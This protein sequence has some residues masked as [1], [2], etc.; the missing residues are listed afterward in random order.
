M[1]PFANAGTGCAT[2]A[3]DTFHRRRCDRRR[4][5]AKHTDAGRGRPP[6]I[7]RGRHAKQKNRSP[8]PPPSQVLAR[9]A[10]KRLAVHT[11]SNGSRPVFRFEIGYAPNAGRVDETGENHDGGVGGKCPIQQVLSRCSRVPFRTGA[12]TTDVTGI[13]VVVGRRFICITSSSCSR[14]VRRHR[15]KTARQKMRFLSF[16]V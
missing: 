16:D 11:P 2:S 7:S 10:Y 15:K 12:E 6:D 4:L 1:W 13:S 5:P 14:R 3:A 9:Y 8:P